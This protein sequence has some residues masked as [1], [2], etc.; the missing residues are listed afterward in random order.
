MKMFF[1]FYNSNYDSEAQ[2]QAYADEA[3]VHAA[4]IH[5][6]V[7]SQAVNV[8]W[9]SPAN[10]FWDSPETIECVTVD[11]NDKKEARLNPSSLNEIDQMIDSL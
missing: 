9:K 11:G 2:A 4:S 10:K 5:K 7:T 3:L 6:Q 8:L 1:A